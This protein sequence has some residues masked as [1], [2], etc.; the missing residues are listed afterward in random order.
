MTLLSRSFLSFLERVKEKGDVADGEENHEE[1]HEENHE[2][3][4]L[5]GRGGGKGGSDGEGW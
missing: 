5:W 1:T 2:E 3:A 4:I